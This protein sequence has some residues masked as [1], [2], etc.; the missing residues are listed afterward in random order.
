MNSK[1]FRFALVALAVAS[2]PLLGADSKP[3]V[4]LSSG[5]I[6]H[7]SSSQYFANLKN[8]QP[9]NS[10]Q[11]CLAAGGRLPKGA[12]HKKSPGLESSDTNVWIAIAVVVVLSLIALPFVGRWRR[13]WRNRQTRAQYEEAEERRWRGH[14]L[15]GGS[16]PKDEG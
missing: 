2:S 15:G 3:A 11:E 5:G 6:C 14:K 1:W 13:R 7:D 9:F 8:Y 16:T 4:K 10:M 12:S